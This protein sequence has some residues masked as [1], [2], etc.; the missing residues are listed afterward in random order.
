MEHDF[1]ELWFGS[2]SFPNGLMAVGEP[3]GLEL[4]SPPT[5]LTRDQGAKRAAGVSVANS[6][7]RRSHDDHRLGSHMDFFHLGVSKNNGIPKSSI[8]IGFSIINQY[9]P[10]ILGNPYFWKH[11]F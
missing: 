4:P 6:P 10:S 8:L 5:P 1:L 7:Q 2:F 9:K 11:P 3:A